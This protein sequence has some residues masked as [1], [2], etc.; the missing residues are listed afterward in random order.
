MHIFAKQL[1]GKVPR[2]PPVRGRRN[3][4]VPFHHNDCQASFL[5]TFSW[6]G[7]RGM[8]VLQGPSCNL[9]N[10][11]WA[12]RTTS[13]PGLC[14]MLT[15][16]EFPAWKEMKAKELRDPLR[17][18]YISQKTL[19]A[20]MVLRSQGKGGPPKNGNESI[21]A[22]KVTISSLGR[23]WVFIF[24]KWIGPHQG[25]WPSFKSSSSTTHDDHDYSSHLWVGTRHSSEKE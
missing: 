9:P 3:W 13:A 24:F 10:S 12:L 1:L 6:W 22:P 2:G 7:G 20:K 15:I 4:C 11:L 21:P 18:V 5:L 16:T 14:F 23:N 25:M 8:F 17:P 19:D